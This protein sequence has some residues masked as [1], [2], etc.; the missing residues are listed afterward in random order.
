MKNPNIFITVIFQI[1]Q[2]KYPLKINILQKKQIVKF[3][4]QNPS[5]VSCEMSK[6]I[7]SSKFHQDMFKIKIENEKNL[8]SKPQ[9]NGQ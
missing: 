5:T 3:Y 9:D 8:D 1:L 7:F 2:G 4:F 6:Y